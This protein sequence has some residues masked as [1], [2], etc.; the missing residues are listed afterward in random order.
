MTEPPI[1]RPK[2]LAD[3]AAIADADADR[4]LGHAAGLPDDDTGQSLRRS[5]FA[6]ALAMLELADRLRDRATLETAKVAEAA[7]KS[8]GTA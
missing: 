3:L 2:T 7:A 4:L 5:L 8:G 6:E 1:D